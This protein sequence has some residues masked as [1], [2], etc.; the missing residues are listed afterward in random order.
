MTKPIIRLEI[1][2]RDEY[3]QLDDYPSFLKLTDLYN[4]FDIQYVESDPDIILCFNQGFVAPH[5][6]QTRKYKTLY[7]NRTDICSVYITGEAYPPD[8]AAFDFTVSVDAIQFRDRHQQVSIY[9]AMEHVE[10][11][12]RL[13]HTSIPPLSRADL[14]NRTGFCSWLTSNYAPH[15]CNPLRVEIFKRISE[16]KT[17]S[18]G[19]W[20]FNNI[21]GLIDR[22]PEHT[23]KFI[24]Q[25]KF[26]LA[27]E[28]AWYPDYVTEK[29]TR[30]L[31][32]RVIPIFWGHPSV[33]KHF[34]PAS[35]INVSD[36]DSWEALIDR[37]REL[38][39]DDDQYLEM[40]NTDPLECTGDWHTDGRQLYALR[41]F[42]HR[43][44]SLPHAQRLRRV[45][46]LPTVTTLPLRYV[47]P[48]NQRFMYLQRIRYGL[49]RKI[50]RRLLPFLVELISGSRR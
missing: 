28:N 8:F 15:S 13:L 48:V 10:F 7:K 35:Y 32:N 39:E 18:S 14:K 29:I 21:G 38:D 45:N 47:V 41:N 43:I 3:K 24:G 5:F 42:L 23:I 1:L 33:R 19:G 44:F 27:L 30:S 46:R 17:V 36:Y 49:K 9:A 12:E 4:D 11:Y 20:E 6:G 25:H 37:I 34:N 16:Y 31:A 26:H 40:V 2:T 50:R 22:S